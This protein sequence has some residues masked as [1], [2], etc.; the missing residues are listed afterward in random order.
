[1]KF[2]IKDLFS[3]CDRIR[4]FLKK[5]LNRK[6]NFLC[7]DYKYVVVTLTRF[8]EIFTVSGKLRYSPG[9]TAEPVVKT[10]TNRVQA[11]LINSKNSLI[12]LSNQYSLRKS[13]E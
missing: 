7:S 5:I 9:L 13:V 10:K 8:K 12:F 2:S 1:M 4:S 6:L 3:K 11:I